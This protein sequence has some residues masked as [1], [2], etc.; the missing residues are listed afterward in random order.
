[1]AADISIMMVMQYLGSQVVRLGNVGDINPCIPF[2]RLNKE[3]NL[4]VLETESLMSDV[5]I[6]RI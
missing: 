2:P 6:R 5:G 4:V 1:M 3:Q